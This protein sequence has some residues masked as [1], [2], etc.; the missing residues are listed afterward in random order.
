MRCGG[1]ISA[2]VLGIKCSCLPE[3]KH[4]ASVHGQVA[5]HFT[6]A[7]SVLALCHLNG[8]F[9]LNVESLCCSSGGT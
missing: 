7:A 8:Q 6:A 3:V 1:E 4:S 5:D 9:S 2:T